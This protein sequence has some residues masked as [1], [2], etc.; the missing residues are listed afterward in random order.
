[1]NILGFNNV[2]VS[3]NN[4]QEDHI[5]ELY[6][7]LTDLGFRR[8]IFTLAHD[9]I[10]T[11]ITRHLELKKHCYEIIKR[12]KPRGISIWLESNILLTRES[13]YEDQIKR[14]DL[15]KTKYL[16]T[17]FPLFDAD[18]WIDT[19]LNH[20][21][22]TKKKFPCFMSFDRNIS[23]YPDAFVKHLC[24][25]RCACFMID[26]NAL[27]LPS[28]IPYVNYLIDSNAVIIPGFTGVIADYIALSDKLNFLKASIGQFNYT[29]LLVN[30][31]ISS[32]LL[33]GL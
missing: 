6:S 27:T 8:I 10:S 30:S 28:V 29:K 21:L 9:V 19:T 7:F 23:T 1:M 2:I 22:Y 18:D 26:I 17:T 20:M 5:K 25:T 33:L 12:N 4:F 15:K 24:K 11:P 14:L 31:S 13:I 32:K 3:D 16:L